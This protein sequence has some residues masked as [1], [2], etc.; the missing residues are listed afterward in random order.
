MKHDYYNYDE[1]QLMENPKIPLLI[2]DSADDVFKAMADEMIEIINEKA[3]EKK[4]CVLIIPVGP[5]GQYPYFVSRVNEEKISLKHCYFINMDEYL[6]E[7]LQYISIDDPLSFRGFM[8]KNVYDKISDELNVLQS[9]RIFPDPNNIEYIPQLIE[10]LGGV[11]A[12]F[13]G[14]GINGH[15]AFNEARSDL[16]NDEF[17]NLKTRILEISP[18]TRTCNCIGDLNGALQDMPTHC[19]TVGFNEIYN[20]RK[21]ILGVFRPWHK[22]VIRRAAYGDSTCNFPVSLLQ[23]K[24]NVLIRMPKVVA[25]L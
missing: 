18:E 24:D 7:N 17:I 14:I 21:I 5:V 15:L 8:Q 10:S 12:V 20:A 4:D 22:A 2:M 23:E 1:K 16:T 11:D 9:R 6:D 3:K 25:Q 19:I 13:G